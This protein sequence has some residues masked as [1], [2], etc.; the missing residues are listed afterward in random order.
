MSTPM[1]L[2]DSIA[3]YPPSDADAEDLLMAWRDA[4]NDARLAYLDWIEAGQEDART[5]YAVYVAAADREAVAA[6]V[7]GSWT[8]APA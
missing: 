7:L 1:R 4:A 5:R 2:S 8:G 3:P 6:E